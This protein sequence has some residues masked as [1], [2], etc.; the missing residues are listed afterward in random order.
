MTIYNYDNYAGYSNG[1]DK[2]AM[3]DV[4]RV[5]RTEN[6][7]SGINKREDK[8]PSLYSLS[9]AERDGLPSAYLIYM[10]SVDESDAAMKI[11]GSL[12]H[13]RKLAKLKWFLNGDISISFDGLL[14]WRQDM[15]QR[16]ITLAKK[17]LLESVK[18]GNVPAAK[19][20][21]D[22]YKDAIPKNK[23]GRPLKETQL[24][25]VPGGLFAANKIAEIHSKRFDKK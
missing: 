10:N 12:R 15:V 21:L 6:L 16:D 9:E 24:E 14:N 7:F 23:V 13:W 11:V 2:S 18:K 8:Y 20:L 3:F 5:Q 17:T 19:R 22:E 4:R 1:A 25:E